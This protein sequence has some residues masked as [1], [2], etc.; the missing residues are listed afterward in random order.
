MGIPTQ[1]IRQGLKFLDYPW[2][3]P[4][5]LAPQGYLVSNKK[6]HGADVDEAMMSRGP[7]GILWGNRG[8]THLGSSCTTF[9]MLSFYPNV[10]ANMQKKGK[11]PNWPLQ[12]RSCN[13]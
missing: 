9:P 6:Q 7:E 12:S 10:K 8:C 3:Q 13:D 1:E 11:Q 2:L 5:Q 4:H